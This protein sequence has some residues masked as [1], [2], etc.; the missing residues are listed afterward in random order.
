MTTCLRGPLLHP[1][2]TV[3]VRPPGVVQLGWDPERALLL[4]LPG[5]SAD[6]LLAF[7]R[8]LD[9]LRTRPQIIWRAGEFGIAPDDAVALLGEID[10]AGLL[11]HPE[12]R[13]GRLRSV[14]V[15]GLGPLSDAISAG[16]RRHGIRP[17]R[18]RGS[19]DG[20]VAGWRTELVVLADTVVIEPTLSNELVLHRIPHVQVCLR[21]GTGRVGPLVLP[22][23]T[24]CLR[25][26]DLTRCHY[27]A[28]WPLLAAQLLGRT[29]YASP[30]GTAATAALA[31]GE[32]EAIL[33]C[34]PRRPPA[35]L[36]TTLELDLESHLVRRRRWPLHPGC[37]CR[38]LFAGPEA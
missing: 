36:N 34:S 20:A 37:G 14:R 23:A 29:G 8:A 15:H 38:R 22:G 12:D 25:C 7:L 17:T 2:V 3:L 19:A 16:L 18:S 4:T 11:V 24:S 35:T 32:L 33:A 21:D 10:E 27:D 9:G 26:A 1:K 31:L 28:D 5:V 6:A 30:A 13:A